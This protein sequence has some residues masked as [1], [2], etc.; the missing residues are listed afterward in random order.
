MPQGYAN[1]GI[2]ILMWLHCIIDSNVPDDS[3]LSTMLADFK[4]SA[5]KSPETGS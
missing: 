3:D 5:S 2:P 4:A 1:S